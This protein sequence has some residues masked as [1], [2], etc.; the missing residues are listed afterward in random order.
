MLVGATLSGKTRCWEVLADALNQLN[1]E[2][3][4]RGVK[5]E[6]FKDQAVKPELINPKS[7]TTDELY[8]FSDD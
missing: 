8:G 5:P 7:I 3:K 4:E 2:E 1:T 6:D